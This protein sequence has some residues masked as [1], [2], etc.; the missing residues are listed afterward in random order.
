MNYLSKQIVFQEVPNEVAMSFLI[1]GC[2]LKCSGCHSASA[3]NKEIGTKLSPATLGEAIKPYQEFITTVLF[4]WGEWEEDV[5][6]ELITTTKKLWL[7]AALYTG[8][9]IGEVSSSLLEKLNYIK[10]GRWV[11][12][13]G[14]LDSPTTNQR[15]YNLNTKEDITYYFNWNNEKLGV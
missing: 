3:W 4:L 1:T 2:P 8:L 13:L 15:M 11:Q 10:V 14:G 6:M 12:E 7:K 9:G 5:L